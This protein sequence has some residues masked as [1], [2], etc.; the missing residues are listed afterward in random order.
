M[1]Y[2]TCQ[3]DICKILQ[4]QTLDI[5]MKE[6]VVIRQNASTELTQRVLRTG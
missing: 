1:P 6:H 3:P 2:G 5:M 4:I